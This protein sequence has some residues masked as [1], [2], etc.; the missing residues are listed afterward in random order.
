MITIAAAALLLVATL[1]VWFIAQGARPAAR[2]QIRFAGVLFAALPL[3]VVALP[4]AAPVVALLVLPIGLGVL[5]LAASAGFARAA[6][7][8]LAAALLALICMAGLAAA[9]TG[10]MILSLAPCAAAIVALMMIFV[11]QFDAAR[12]ASVQGLLSALCFLGAVSSFASDGVGA[13]LLLFA[14]AGLLGTGLALS[15]SDVVVEERPVRDLRGL[16]AIGDRRQ[17]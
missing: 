11:R 14:A 2:V 15:R 1:A 13:A 9:V 6:P 7:T 4:V 8:G 16:A 12:A 17:A 5:G 10:W 3:A